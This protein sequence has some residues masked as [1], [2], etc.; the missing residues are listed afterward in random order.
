M[1]ME[2]KKKSDQEAKKRN[3]QLEGE[4]SGF[5]APR[6]EIENTNGVRLSGES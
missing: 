2:G 3:G 5:F 1:S 4:K 6:A